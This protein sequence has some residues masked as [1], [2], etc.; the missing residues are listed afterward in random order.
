MRLL[1]P[2]YATTMP[3]NTASPAAWPVGR[4]GRSLGR[5]LRSH[6]RADCGPYESTQRPGHRRRRAARPCCG[7]LAPGG[8]GGVFL[9]GMVW[10]RP[11]AVDG[12]TAAVKWCLHQVC[13]RPAGIAAVAQL[14]GR[15][16]VAD[17]QCIGRRWWRRTPHARGPSKRTHARSLWW[18]RPA[19]PAGA[20]Q[21]KSSHFHD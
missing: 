5:G 13:A 9:V 8:P 2:P 19:L 14:H 3:A 18:P 20:T 15:T 17:A 10:L 4:P 21:V 16:R 1:G 6:Q 11:S 12:P 7:P